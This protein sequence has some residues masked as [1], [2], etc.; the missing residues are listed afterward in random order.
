MKKSTRKIVSRLSSYVGI[1]V[2]RTKPTVT[3]DWSKTDTPIL[4]LGFTSDG[5][6]RYR[7]L[8]FERNIFGDVEYTLPI[9]FTD[10]N[11]ITYKKAMKPKNNPLNKWRGKKIKRVRPTATCGDCSFMCRNIW[12][13]APTLVSASKYHMVISRNDSIWKGRQTVLRSDYMDPKDWVLAE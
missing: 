11:W 6:I 7:H 3:G 5:R 2:I 12:D 4:L 8:G 1:E 9:S 10:R 13:A